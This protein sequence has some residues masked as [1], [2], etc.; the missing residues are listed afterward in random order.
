MGAD[1]RRLCSRYHVQGERSM[2]DSPGAGRLNGAVNE[3]P[4]GSRGARRGRDRRDE[5]VPL[6]EDSLRLAA[7]RKIRLD[8]YLKLVG[9]TTTG[10]QAKLLIQAG[11]VRV[12]GELETRRGRGLRPG[13]VV[14][15]GVDVWVV[16]AE[17]WH[18]GSGLTSASRLK[19][20]RIQGGAERSSDKP[21]NR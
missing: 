20:H 21:L 12:N 2:L 15:T 19:R 16:S 13:D 18:E 7:S 6:G 3:E 10:G 17:L 14:E 9:F 4:G 8:Q 1:R 5:P 11:E